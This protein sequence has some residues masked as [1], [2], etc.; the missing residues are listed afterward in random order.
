M[1]ILES[2][3]DAVGRTPLVHLSRI[4]RA[5]SLPFSL[6]AKVEY[7]NPGGSVKDRVAA[8]VLSKA[9][10]D[11]LISPTRTTLI[12]PTSGN[13]GIGIALF[14][15]AHGYKCVIVMPDSMSM[16]RRQLMAAYGAQVV[17]TPGA[18]GMRGAIEEARRMRENDAESFTLGQF[19]NPE[20]PQAHMLSTAPEIYEDMDGDIDAFV[21]GIGTGGT[22]SGVGAYLKAKSSA[23]EVIGVEPESSPMLSLGIGGAHRIQG[24][25]AGFVPKILDRTVIDRI[26]MV[27]DDDAMKTARLLAHKE[28]LAVGISS[29]AAV[30]AAIAMKTDVHYNGKRVVVLLPDSAE[31]YLSVDGFIN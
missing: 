12:E 22:V 29:G 26:I 25:G 31:R 11:G 13:T 24:I 16:E 7:F 27:S 2:I 6:Y 20:N 21:C 3:T 19:D 1:N 15:A 14:A 23:I 28:G 10:R 17:L 5:L 30:A 9:E 18:L 8:H 4:E